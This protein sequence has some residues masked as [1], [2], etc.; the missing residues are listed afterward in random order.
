MGSYQQ[1]ER[2]AYRY[3]SPLPSVGL[4]YERRHTRLFK[5]YGGIKAQM[6][7]YAALFLLIMLSVGLPGL[8]GFIGE[9]LALIGA[10]EAGFFGGLGVR[11]PL[12]IVAATGVIFAAVYLLWMFQK[13]FY[14]PITSYANRRLKDLKP[15]EIAMVGTFVVLAGWGGIFPS[16]FLKPMEA[17]IGATRMMA[18]NRP[19]AARCGRAWTPKWTPT[20]VSF[21]RAR[22]HRISSP[23]SRFSRG[24]WRRPTPTRCSK[25]VRGK[26]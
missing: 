14:G 12:V 3:R 5:D 15:W 26:P 25:S 9:F 4:I 8:N 20:A 13:V 7:I 21:R 19:A 1:L 23:K 18:L 16:T 6:P 17:S 11:L 10:F 24:S 22:A 2:T